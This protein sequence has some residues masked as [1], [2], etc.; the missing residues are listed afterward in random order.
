MWLYL[1]LKQKSIFVEAKQYATK[2]A[3]DHWLN[4]GRNFFKY[5]EKT[6][7]RKQIQNLW[8]AAKSSSKREVYSHIATLIK[9]KLAPINK[10]RMKK[11]GTQTLKKFQKLCRTI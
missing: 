2:Q 7:T 6:K 9:K 4:Q 3:M 8:D 10:I 5:L 11:E 1:K